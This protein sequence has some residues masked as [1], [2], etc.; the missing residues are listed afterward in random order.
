M[1]KTQHK[2]RQRVVPIPLCVEFFQE[3]PPLRHFAVR[4]W[5]QAVAVGIIKAVSFMGDSF[6]TRSETI[7]SITAF[8]RH[9]LNMKLVPTFPTL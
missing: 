6:Y 8:L 7:V 1:L 2:T 9:I 5:K 4:D 3:F